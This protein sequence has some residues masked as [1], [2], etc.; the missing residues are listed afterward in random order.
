MSTPEHLRLYLLLGLSAALFC[1]YVY[2]RKVKR[3]RWSEYFALI[4]GPVAACLVLAYYYGSKLLLFFLISALAGFFLEF[5]LGL[6]YHRTLNRRLW[7][8][9]T[10]SVSGYTSWLAL[11]FWGVA[12]VFFWTLSRWIGL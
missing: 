12:G 1:A 8:Y 3:F 6:A 7:T 5:S 4:S 9:S 10:Y 2:G 11:P